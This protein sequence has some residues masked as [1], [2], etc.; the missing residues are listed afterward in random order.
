MFRIL[1]VEDDKNFSNLIKESLISRGYEVITAEDGLKA[2]ACLENDTCDLMICD[3]MMPKMDGFAL[4]KELRDAKYLFPV[5]MITAKG[6]MEDKAEGFQAGTDDYMVKPI[7]M[8]EMLLRVK[9]LMR[10]SQIASTHTLSAGRAV[11]EYESK[12]LIDGNGKTYDLPLKEFQL[13]FYLL[14]TPG[15]TYT[16]QKLLDEIW[17]IDSESTLHTVDVHIARLRDKLCGIED[18]ELVTIRG[19]GYKAVIPE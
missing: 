5:L 13:L 14:S 11:L 6:E 8:D 3:V 1:V 17:G 4:V 2:L 19:L 7:H 9:A 18:F 15:R 16:R 12:S 10:R